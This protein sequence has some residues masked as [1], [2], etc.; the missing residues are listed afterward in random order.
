MARVVCMRV[1]RRRHAP[2][3][4]DGDHRDEAQE[5][6]EE[7]E[8]QTKRAKVHAH[9]DPGRTEVT[10]AAGVKSRCSDV[11]MMTKRSNHIPMFTKI[12]ITNIAGIERRILRN[13]KSCGE[14]TLHE[15]IVQ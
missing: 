15:I 5:Q 3:L 14:M 9:V 13:Q 8:E 7:R 12:E 10:P 11:A 2:D 1:S 6:K 4:R